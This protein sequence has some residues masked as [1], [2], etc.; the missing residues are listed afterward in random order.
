MAEFDILK[1]ANF[2]IVAAEPQENLPADRSKASAEGDGFG[3][4]GL[5]GVVV[6][7][8]GEKLNIGLC[9]DLAC[10]PT[11]VSYWRKLIPRNGETEL[12][13][14]IRRQEL[15]DLGLLLA[16]RLTIFGPCDVDVI[17][18]EFDMRFFGGGYPVSQLAGAGFPELL[19]WALRGERPDLR[20]DFEEDIFMMTTLRP[21]GGRMDQAAAKFLMEDGD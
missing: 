19:V 8:V 1:E 16:A 20:T 13:V 10:R 14:T 5:M 6:G 12:A 7:I 11:G 4:R 3:I 2:R 17:V 9:W 18:I 15:I 21:F